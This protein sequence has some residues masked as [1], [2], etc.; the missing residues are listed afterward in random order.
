METLGIS[1]QLV[2]EFEL[3]VIRLTEGFGKDPFGRVSTDSG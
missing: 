3:E 2:E 1:C